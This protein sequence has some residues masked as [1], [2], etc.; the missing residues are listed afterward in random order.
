MT[1]P[2]AGVDRRFASLLVGSPH[3]LVSGQATEHEV[4]AQ[5]VGEARR[6]GRSLG[7]VHGRWMDLGTGG[8]LPGLVLAWLHPQAEWVL[9]DATQK[10]ASEVRRFARELEVECRVVAGRAED[11][12]WQAGWR[13]AFDAVVVRALGSLRVTVELAR[14][15]LVDGGRLLAVKG[16]TAPEEVD[17]AR[18][19]LD[20]VAMEVE[21]VTRLSDATRVVT[22]RAV[23]PAPEGVPRRSGVPQRR[24]W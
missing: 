19:A 6:L 21:S 2:G 14:G 7:R 8:G 15:F 5:H 17:A 20:R 18:T 12:A 9:V 10:K 24:P 16:P 4:L 1:C 23:G 11:L 22:V 3:N 13:E